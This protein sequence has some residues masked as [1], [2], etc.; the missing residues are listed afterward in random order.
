MSIPQQGSTIQPL[1]SVLSSSSAHIFGTLSVSTN[2]IGDTTSG[3]IRTPHSS[4]IFFDDHLNDQTA[5]YL[6]GPP[7][8]VNDETISTNS[9]RLSSFNLTNSIS[10]THLSHIDEEKTASSTDP[11]ALFEAISQQNS[12]KTTSLTT[13]NNPSLPVSEQSINYVDLLLPTHSNNND[14]SESNDQQQLN[15]SEDLTDQTNE[16][17]EQECE[18]NDLSF[19]KLYT[20]IDFHQTQRRDRIVQ[21][22]AK[23]KL[24]DQPPP[25]VL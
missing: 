13:I 24:E 14:N 19:T 17:E 11:Y 16:Y 25:F 23:A 1:D 3:S 7:P 2:N 21:S 9:S 10:R 5:T 20:D 8:I 6:L 12:P 4:I 22:A 18:N 15:H